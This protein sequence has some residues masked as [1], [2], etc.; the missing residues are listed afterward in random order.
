MVVAVVVVPVVASLS[1]DFAYPE[2]VVQHSDQCSAHQ[3]MMQHLSSRNCPRLHA[4]VMCLSCHS[5]E[6][7]LQ[8]HCFCFMSAMVSISNVTGS[9]NTAAVYLCVIHYNISLIIFT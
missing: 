1:V 3:C 6:L 9:L 5:A 2:L 7:H 4:T 8:K